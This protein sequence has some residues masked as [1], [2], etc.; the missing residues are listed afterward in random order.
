M[1][2]Y[3]AVVKCSIQLTIAYRTTYIINILFS[4]VSALL[5]LCLWDAV[6]QGKSELMNFSWEE[7]KAYIMIVFIINTDLYS[8]HRCSR[9]ILDGS[10]IMDLIKPV[11]H[12][13]YTLSEILGSIL[14]S[15]TLSIVISSIIFMVFGMYT[16]DHVLVWLL[17]IISLGLALFIKYLIIF[18]FS[19]FSFWTHNVTGTLWTRVAITNFFS[20]ALIPISFFPEWLQRIALLLPFQGIINT[21]VII[22]TMQVSF[23]QMI[24]SIYLQILWIIVIW[25]VAKFLFRICIQNIVINGG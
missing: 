8:E 11:Q 22:F 23:N 19:L 14:V 20:G 25:I 5:L 3:I 13:E 1:K 7:M 16:P 17:F 24:L 18:V 12:Q 21:P 6:Y 15:I 10:I 2:K 9:K 4:L